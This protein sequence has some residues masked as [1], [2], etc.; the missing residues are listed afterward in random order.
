MDAHFSK[1]LA[2]GGNAA[3]PASQVPYVAASKFEGRR[4][5]YKFQ[6]GSK[7]IGYYHDRTQANNANR[8]HATDEAITVSC[9]FSF[10]MPKFVAN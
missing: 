10:K 5:G 7:G 3:H 9:C 6:N 8:L 4:D 1:I 2:P